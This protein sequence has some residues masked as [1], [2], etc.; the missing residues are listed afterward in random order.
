MYETEIYLKSVCLNK[1]LL[2]I[3]ILK[4]RKHYE[5]DWEENVYNIY[6]TV[7]PSVA[8]TYVPGPNFVL[9]LY[10]YQQFQYGIHVP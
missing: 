1:F 3:R 7:C 4:G 9:L 2:R 5:E 10:L 8:C 6:L